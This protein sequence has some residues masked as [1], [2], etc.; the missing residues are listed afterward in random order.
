MRLEGDEVFNDWMVGGT[1][2]RGG[3]KVKIRCLYSAGN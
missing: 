3:E 2:E 1:G